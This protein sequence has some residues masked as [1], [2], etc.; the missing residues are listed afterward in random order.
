MSI[1]WNTIQPVLRARWRRMVYGKHGCPICNGECAIHDVVDF[2][3]TCLN[4]GFPQS[5]IRVPYYRCMNCGFCFA[6]TI[7]QWSQA[8]FKERIYNPEYVLVDPE[9]VEKRPSANAQFLL[10]LL[11]GAGSS[12]RHLDYGGGDGLLSR[13]LQQQGW[14]SASYDPIADA[15]TSPVGHDQYDLISAFEVFEHVPSPSQ[16]MGDLTGLLASDGIILFSTL[17]SDGHLSPQG[18][19]TWWYA[20]PRNG[21]ISLFSRRSLELLAEKNQLNFGSLTEGLHLMWRHLPSWAS[22]IFSS[23]A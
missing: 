2:S 7:A 9:Y 4:L 11:G 14:Q 3:K 21:H 13:I 16:L 12:I 5:G 19:L 1:L 8:E 17:L 18:G 15:G 10:S 6:P 22:H 23:A 20:S